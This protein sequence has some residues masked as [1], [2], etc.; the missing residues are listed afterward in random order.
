MSSTTKEKVVSQDDLT[1]T[2]LANVPADSNGGTLTIRQLK[3]TALGTREKDRIEKLIGQREQ[4]AIGYLDEMQQFVNTANDMAPFDQQEELDKI[5][6][7]KALLKLQKD[8]ISVTKKSEEEA[9]MTILKE[10]LNTKLARLKRV[11]QRLQDLH[12]RDRAQIKGILD[13]KF[14]RQERA[15]VTK[16]AG[17]VTRKDELTRFKESNKALRTMALNNSFNQLR[18]SL[19]DAKNRAIELLWTAIDPEDGAKIMGM[20]PDVEKFREVVSPELLFDMFNH[21][22]D[23]QKEKY[24]GLKCQHCQSTDLVFSGT[25]NMMCK[26]CGK[27]STV[28]RSIL[29]LVALPSLTELMSRIKARRDAANGLVPKITAQ[30]VEVVDGDVDPDEIVP[31]GATAVAAEKVS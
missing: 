1:T 8:R 29:Q 17:F 26:K 4:N 2:A 22:L 14:Q 19:R 21:S 27:Y 25:Q 30:D 31:A 12:N 23:C 15:M 7:D 20:I 18:Q 11:E 16:E 6:T 13:K 24:T 28:D 9:A 10:E 5:E 3:V